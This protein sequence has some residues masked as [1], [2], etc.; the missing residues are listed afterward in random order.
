MAIIR[1]CQGRETGPIPVTRSFFKKCY[2]LFQTKHFF[3]SSID[4]NRNLRI[5]A[6]TSLFSLKK[7]LT[8]FLS[9]KKGLIQLVPAIL[10]LPVKAR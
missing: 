10:P 6:F 3:S 4:K 5:K 2:F 7:S 1:P 8:Q 9:F